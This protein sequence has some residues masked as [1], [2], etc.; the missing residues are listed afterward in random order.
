MGRGDWRCGISLIRVSLINQM[1]RRGFILSELIILFS[2]E[3]KLTMPLKG[4]PQQVGVEGS[5]GRTAR[6]I[7]FCHLHGLTTVPVPSESTRNSIGA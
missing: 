5:T 3:L 7:G 2:N 1:T 6:D 4:I